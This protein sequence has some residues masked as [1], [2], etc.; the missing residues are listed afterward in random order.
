MFPLLGVEHD[1]R[2]LAN[3]KN[4]TKQPEEWSFFIVLAPLPSMRLRRRRLFVSFTLIARR[5]R[6]IAFVSLLLCPR[7]VC[8]CAFV[9]RLIETIICVGAST[10]SPFSLR[11]WDRR[12]FVSLNECIWIKHICFLIRTKADRIEPFQWSFWTADVRSIHLNHFFFLI[13]ASS[14]FDFAFLQPILRQMNHSKCW[15]DTDFY[16][17]F[18]RSSPTICS[19]TSDNC[20]VYI[21]RS[22]CVCA[23]SDDGKRLSGDTDEAQQQ[24]MCSVPF[25]LIWLCLFY[26]QQQNLHR[27]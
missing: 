14:S 25:K 24:Q 12:L 27:T 11:V 3:D 18:Y 8:V 19:Q 17:H 13:F 5:Q 2:A 4:D 20:F 10:T 15:F 9:V 7:F 26:V 21:T 22:M 6:S 16:R 1:Q 23:S